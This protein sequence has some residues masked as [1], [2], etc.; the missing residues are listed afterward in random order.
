MEIIWHGHACFSL[1]SGGYTLLIDPYRPGTAAGFPALD[2]EADAVVCS[3][4]HD[5]HGAVGSVRLRRRGVASPF[6]I[7]DMATAH[8]VMG[9]RLRGGN[10]VH[11]IRA[12]GLKIVHLG[13]LGRRLTPE[14]AG[15]IS[16]ADA[17]MAPIGGILTLEPY[18][19]YELCRAASPRLIIP[20]HYYAAKGSRRLRRPEE[21]LS[22]FEPGE[23]ELLRTDRLTLPSPGAL[24]RLLSAAGGAE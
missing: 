8:D 17:L 13:D 5:G 7:E 15:R 11:I 12:E 23:V 4:G 10:T 18:P 6:V 3:H 21:F 16:G 19:V 9:G 24:V 22:L 1:V 20:M 14:E 2:A